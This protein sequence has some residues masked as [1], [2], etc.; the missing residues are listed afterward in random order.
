MDRLD[1]EGTMAAHRSTRTIMTVKRD[2]LSTRG[3]K[4]PTGGDITG[5]KPPSGGSKPA[6]T[7][8]S[9]KKR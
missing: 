7:T 5:M 3:G 2:P 1:W 9:G 4:V 8:E 6:P